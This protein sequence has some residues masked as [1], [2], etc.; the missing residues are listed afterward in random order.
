MK[1]VE[2]K[3]V[4]KSWP[5]NGENRKFLDSIDF[6]IHPGDFIILTGE[7]GAGKSTL[8]NLITGAEEPDSGTVLL[9]GKLP[10]QSSS[11]RWVGYMHQRL[12]SPK[13]LKVEEF[14][15]LFRSYYEQPLP[16]EQ[17]LNRSQLQNKRKDFAA[18][19]SGGQERKLHFALAIAGDPKFLILD[20]PFENLDKNFKEQILLQ[21]EEL[22]YKEKTIL[23]ICHNSFVIEQFSE[24]ATSIF[25]LKDGQLNNIFK[26]PNK[27]QTTAKQENSWQASELIQIKQAIS[28]LTRQTQAE[29]LQLLRQPLFLFSILVLYCLVAILPP[30]IENAFTT[31]IAAAGF[32]L[33]LTAIQTFGLQIATERKEGWLKVLQ[34]TPLPP[35]V[36]LSSKI[37]VATLI[38]AIGITIVFGLGIFKFGI[39]QPFFSW[40]APFL[41]LLIGILPFDLFGFA[42]AHLFEAGVI[43]LI[44]MPII[45]LAVFTSGCLALPGMPIW[46]QDLIPFSPF[47]HYGQLAMWAA[48]L[49]NGYDGFLGLHLAWLVWTTCVAAV[50]ATWAY[51]QKRSFG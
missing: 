27:V 14:I 18:M 26:E 25:E 28:A 42:I 3:N 13:K 23:L 35:W 2:F 51:R 9:F 31:L 29:L 1:I 44:S 34:T 40:L 10:T 8:V 19:V 41:C 7:N 16:L 12:S 38:S 49:E 39:S 17:L 21:I 50:L 32:S 11:K 47:Y 24:R 45:G 15:N 46:L 20:E 30:D 33:L 5:E 36:Y 4:S 22:L 48:R 6:T 37:I 43:S